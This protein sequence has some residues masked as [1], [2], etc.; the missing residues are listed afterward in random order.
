MPLGFIT[1]IPYVIYSTSLPIEFCGVF[2]AKAK[3]DSYLLLHVLASKRPYGDSELIGMGITFYLFSGQ[4]PTGYDFV[5][6][7]FWRDAF[8]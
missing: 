6:Q 3:L 5:I 8:L 1:V 2:V 4:K 7:F